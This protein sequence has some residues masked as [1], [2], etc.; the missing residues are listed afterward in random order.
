[1]G[2]DVYAAIV[3][4]NL[5]DQVENG[6]NLIII[7][8]FDGKNAT[9]SIARRLREKRQKDGL[10][11]NFCELF[12]VKEAS[13]GN[14]AFFGTTALKSKAE[15]TFPLWQCCAYLLAPLSAL[16]LSV[17][18]TPNSNLLNCVDIKYF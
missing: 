3:R 8:I 5:L 12:T 14:V 2:Q 18:S 1:M 6:W 7:V 11:L 10:L 4:Q 17:Y 16:I 13:E 9:T 15:Q